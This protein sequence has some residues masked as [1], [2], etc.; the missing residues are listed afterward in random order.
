MSNK[1]TRDSSWIS[2]LRARRG[3]T[4]RGCQDRAKGVVN[5]GEETIFLSN[6][7]QERGD[8]PRITPKGEILTTTLIAQRPE[9]R[10][11]VNIA[12]IKIARKGM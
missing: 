8:A 7:S 5:R 12:C 10:T 9:A 2:S 3:G 6:R 1:R 4:R 11:G